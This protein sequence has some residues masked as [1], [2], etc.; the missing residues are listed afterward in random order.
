MALLPRETSERALVLVVVGSAFA[1][2]LA[3]SIPFPAQVDLLRVAFWIVVT[4]IASAQPV[5]LPRGINGSVTSA[6]LIAALK[7]AWR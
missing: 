3:F 1:I 6:P 5:Y 7:A 4:L 2:L